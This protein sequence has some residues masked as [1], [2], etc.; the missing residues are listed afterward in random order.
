MVPY[1]DGPKLALKQFCHRDT[2]VLAGV[3][4]ETQ[5]ELALRL[6]TE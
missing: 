5:L 3:A 6:C 2:A 1:V 4:P